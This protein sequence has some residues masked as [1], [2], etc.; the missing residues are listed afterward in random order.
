MT[1]QKET[2]M[3]IKTVTCDS[4]SRDLGSTGNS[5][6]YRLL[7]T[8]ERLPLLGSVCTD[9]M[10][11]PPIESPAHFCGLACLRNWVEKA[12]APKGKIDSYGRPY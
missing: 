7:L 3:G 4:C 9:M 11:Y 10:I 8:S 1:K 5:V 2:T 12:L 6:D